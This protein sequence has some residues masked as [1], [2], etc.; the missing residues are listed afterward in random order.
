MEPQW[1]ADRQVNARNRFAREILRRKNYQIRPAAIEIVR[2]GHEIAFVFDGAG[3]HGNKYGF[4][5]RAVLETV[6][7][8]RAAFKIV[9]E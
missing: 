4:A 7:L 3:R 1:H 8:E 6:L 5:R 2:I 9:F